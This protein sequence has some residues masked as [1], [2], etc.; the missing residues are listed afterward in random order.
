MTMDSARLDADGIQPLAT[1]VAESSPAAEERAASSRSRLECLDALR[2]IAASVV[3]F[4][5]AFSM[6]PL[7]A[8]GTLP[9]TLFR[10]ES[11]VF[12]G[13][14]AVDLFFVLSGFVLTLPYVGQRAKQMDYTDFIVRRVTRLYPAYWIAVAAALASRLLFGDQLHASAL[15]EWTAKH[16]TAPLTLSEVLRTLA[17]VLPMDDLALNTV[18]WTLL[19]EMQVSLLLP[20]F[21][22][23]FAAA[24]GVRGTL[25]L[26]IACVVITA[27]MAEHSGLQFLPLF[28]LGIALAKYQAKIITAL[29]T[30]ARKWSVALLLLSLVLIEVRVFVPWR[31]PD[32]R[33]DYISGVGAGLLIMLVLAWP[34]LSR[35]LVNPVTRLLGTASYSLYLLHLPILLAVVPPLYAYTGSVLAC[36]AGGFALSL[37][38]AQGVYRLIELPCQESGRQLAKRVAGWTS[39]R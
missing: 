20:F 12:S 9:G 10:I 8:S 24:T 35:G 1:K 29:G 21:I 37:I 14:A 32:L 34:R 4:Q 25:L 18:F 38:V 33:P 31:F 13:A 39:A 6:F 30:L 23:V 17:M 11:R 3:F 27:T 15:T 22:V 19:V 26:F 5:H 16:W 28:A 36:V 7:P 2:G